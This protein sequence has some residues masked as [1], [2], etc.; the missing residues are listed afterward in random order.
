MTE[1]TIDRA[2]CTE[3]ERAGEL[4]RRSLLKAL[5]VGAAVATASPLVGMRAAFAAD[6]GWSG[7]TVIVLSLRGGFDGLSAVAPLGVRRSAHRAT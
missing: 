4:T 2:C 5:G 6:P 3:G 7:D 1:T